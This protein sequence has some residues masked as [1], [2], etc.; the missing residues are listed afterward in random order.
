LNNYAGV[1]SSSFRRDDFTVRLDQNF[2]DK[3]RLYARITRRDN[4]S[5][6]NYWAGPATGGVRPSWQTEL[7]SA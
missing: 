4:E 6:P 5:N 2:G 7:G 1:N 3:H